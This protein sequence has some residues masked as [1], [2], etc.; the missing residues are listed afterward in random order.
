MLVQE[1]NRNHGHHG[2]RGMLMNWKTMSR[3]QDKL[4]TEF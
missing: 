2:S 3:S 4:T 1:L